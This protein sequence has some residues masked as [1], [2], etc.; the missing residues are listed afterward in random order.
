MTDTTPAGPGTGP[1]SAPLRTAPASTA[2]LNTVTWWE[3]PVSD[4]DRA[5]AFLGALFGWTFSTFGDD[6]RTLGIHHDG[7]LIGGLYRADGDP[8]AGPSI[9]AY[10]NVADLEAVLDT[11]QALGGSVRRGRTEVGD[12]M[13]W[14][15]EISDPDGRPLGLCTDNPGRE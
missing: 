10:L 13:G 3:L 4:P 5:T 11:A 6:G 14:W 12:D 1:S 7:A 15:A 9:R 8:A 2:P